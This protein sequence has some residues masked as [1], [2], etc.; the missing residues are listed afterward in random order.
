MVHQYP[1]QIIN[2]KIQRELKASITIN[3]N[4]TKIELKLKDQSA[5]RAGNH[6]NGL[7]INKP[8]DIAGAVKKTA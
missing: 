1:Y 6:R 7:L 2:A 5:Q 8:E 4:T 3:F